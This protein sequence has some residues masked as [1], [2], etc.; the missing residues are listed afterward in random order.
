MLYSKSK[1]LAY[2]IVITA[3]K[4]GV[5]D[6]EMVTCPTSAINLRVRDSLLCCHAPPAH[7]SSGDR[8]M[9]PGW[10]VL[11]IFLSINDRESQPDWT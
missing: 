6:D 5:F 4:S 7:L 2:S 1:L 10:G 8:L 3:A 11:T 9:E